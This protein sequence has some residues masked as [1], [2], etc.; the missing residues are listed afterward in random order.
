M[1]L[2]SGRILAGLLAGLLLSF[3]GAWSLEVLPGSAPAGHAHGGGYC[4]QLRPPKQ[5]CLHQVTSLT[6]A[7]TAPS[8][9]PAVVPAL[10]LI[11]VSAPTTDS[12]SGPRRTSR[13]PPAP[14]HRLP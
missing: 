9:H 7:P 8:L 14:M 1:R 6:V 13:A 3:S 4:G 11:Q 5:P 2:V 10:T 12:L